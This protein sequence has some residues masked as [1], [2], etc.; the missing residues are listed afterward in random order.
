[1]TR[2]EGSVRN[3]ASAFAALGAILKISDDVPHVNTPALFG[4]SVLRSSSADILSLFFRTLTSN[5]A[6]SSLTCQCITCRPH[7]ASLPLLNNIRLPEHFNGQSSPQ[8]RG[9]LR[10]KWTKLE[11][12]GEKLVVV[13]RGGEMK[14]G[15]EYMD[16][17]KL[18]SSPLFNRDASLVIAKLRAS[19]AGLYRCELMLDM[20]NIQGT[21]SLNITGVVFHYRAKTSR[22]S[23]DFPKAVEACLMAGA[24]IA[25]PEQL[26]VAYE[27]GLDQCDAGW[28]SDQTVRYPIK[29]PRPG[30]A[31]D[32]MGKPGVRT[33]GVRDLSEKYDVY[34]FIDQLQAKVPEPTTPAPSTLPSNSE[35]FDRSTWTI[36]TTAPANS[37]R[38]QIQT[39]ESEPMPHTATTHNPDYTTATPHLEFSHTSSHAAVHVT[40]AAFTDDYDIQ[41]FENRTYLESVPIRGDVLPPLEVPPTPSSSSNSSHTELDNSPSGLREDPS[42]T[43][44]EPV[45]ESFLENRLIVTPTQVQDSSNPNM[46]TEIPQME[47]R[48]VTPEIVSSEVITTDP[49]VPVGSGDLGHPAVVFKEDVT[50]G[51]FEVSGSSAVDGESSGKPPIHVIIV[52]VHSQNQSVEDVLR[53]LNQPGGVDDGPLHLFPQ[54]DVSQGSVDVEGLDVTDPFE[55]SPLSLPSTI[56]FLNGKH[57][58]TFKPDIP[59]EARGDQFEIATPVQIEE[60]QKRDQDNVEAVTPFDYGTIEV[61]TKTDYDYSHSTGANPDGASQVLL[62]RHDEFTSTLA[63][64]AP[65]IT[66]PGLLSSHVPSNGF[67]TYEDMEASGSRGTD[68]SSL[69]GS[70]SGVFPTA[71]ASDVRTDETETGGVEVTTFLP[72]MTT[73]TSSIKI[74][75]EEFEGSASGE[76][77]A[78]GQDGYSPDTH[79][80]TTTLSP[81]FSTLQSKIDGHVTEMPL[82]QPAAVVTTESEASSKHFDRE[83]ELFDKNVISSLSS[84]AAPQEH[85]THSPL[86]ATSETRVTSTESD[87]Q[88]QTPV[89]SLGSKYPVTSSTVTAKLDTSTP[90]SELIDKAFTENQTVTSTTVG[91]SMSPL[92][93]F[94]SSTNSVP[95]WALVPDPNATPLP[96]NFSDYDREIAPPLESQPK[97]PAEAAALEEPEA[98]TYSSSVEASTVNLRDLLPCASSLCLNGGSCYK[99]SSEILCVCAPGYTGQ[100]CETDVDECQS[101]PCLNGA[102]CLD[103]VNSFTCLCLP[104]YAGELCERDT[105]VCGLGWQKF[106]SHCYKYFTHR[107]TWDSAERECRIHGGHLAS[108]L[109]HEEQLFVN[110]LGSDYQWIG[111]NDKMFERDFR[112]TD[113]RAMQYDH[114]RPNQPDSFFQS[115]EDCVVMIWH[116]GGQWNDVPCNYHLTFTCKKGTVS[117]GQPPVV[118]DARVFGA[119]R[120]RYEINTLV[121]YH[122]NQGFIQRHTPTVRCRANGQWDVPK[123]TC[124]TPATYHKALAVKHRNRESHQQPNKHFNHHIHL[125]KTHVKHSQEQQQNNYGIFQRIWNPFQQL[126]NKPQAESDHIEP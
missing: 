36:S 77:E 23:L 8:H 69:E 70:G 120:P 83:V 47:V 80:F 93:T 25:T 10:I 20:D 42:S 105:E 39:N 118:K 45:K 44:G 15:Q 84:T 92:Y 53:F 119:L 63:Y 94:D 37:E 110:R 43:S 122:C 103:G 75:T 58:V 68:D 74:Q 40:T 123:V 1:M 86:V 59:E 18:P 61:H 72:D 38:L 13:A 112:W 52:N 106:Q 115:G 98:V 28:L 96:D 19:D 9:S 81:I 73:T 55:A 66:S 11:D 46:A 89:P 7:C 104:S 126:L 107:R 2:A 54:I 3:D 113:G 12:D 49:N 116:E 17:V 108:I 60:G 33:Y 109:S 88:K 121:R 65:P 34:C 14:V 78:S 48:G 56:S 111:L 102:T 125:T 100:H 5:G 85:S 16:R 87:I 114:W 117:C 95:D 97:N 4:V 79:R 6:K 35:D 21:V 29:V 64:T 90:H 30:C 82:G 41:D 26:S 50:T 24:A 101:S 51:Q 76:D 62:E 99:R 32:L 27:D 124:I 31:G 57:E 22:Y 67:S 71:I 91:S